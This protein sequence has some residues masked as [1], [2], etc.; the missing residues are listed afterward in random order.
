M[1]FVEIILCAIS[2]YGN[3]LITLDKFV[4]HSELNGR[5]CVEDH[6]QFR[7]LNALDMISCI[8]RCTL[9]FACR[10]VFYNGDHKQCEGCSFEYENTT[11]LP[12]SDGT[13]YMRRTG[14]N[15]QLSISN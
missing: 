14:K 3:N 5:L 11:G 6:R 10:G 7:T 4:I 13:I 1:L 12:E 8:G 9:N 15:I 2:I